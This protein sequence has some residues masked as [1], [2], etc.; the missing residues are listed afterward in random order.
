M[1]D[2]IVLALIKTSQRSK[3]NSLRF[4][5]TSVRILQK[6]NAVHQEEIITIITC[7]LRLIG[8]QK[9]NLL[10]IF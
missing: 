6:V 9:A 1:H 5:Y 10:I 3:Q 4:T 7:L 8:N 2:I